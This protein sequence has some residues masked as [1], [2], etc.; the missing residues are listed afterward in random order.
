MDMLQTSG[1]N[2]VTSAL[3]QRGDRLV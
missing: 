2:M 1:V 3:N